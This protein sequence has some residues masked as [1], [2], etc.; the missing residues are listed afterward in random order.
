MIFNVG[1]KTHLKR[2]SSSRVARWFLFKPKIPIW[3]N[4]GGPE[5]GKC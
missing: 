3:V 2:L 1:L 5:I 4:F